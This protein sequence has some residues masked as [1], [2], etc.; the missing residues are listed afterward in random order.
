MIEFAWIK[1]FAALP[2]PLLVYL[3]LPR[4]RSSSGQAL[5]I[6]FFEELEELRQKTASGKGLGWLRLLAV[7]AWILLVCAAARPQWIGDP[8]SMPISG[9]DLLLAVDISGSMKAE[10][11]KISNQ[12]VDRLTMI[13]K[14]AGEFIERRQGDRIGLI[15]FGSRAYLQAPL[16]LDRKTVNQLLQEALIGI[17]GEKTAIGDA[18]G[19]AVKR[20]QQRPGEKKVLIL[21]TDGA[22]T[23]GTIEPLKAAELAKEAKLSIYTIGIG[24]ER[25]IVNSFFG[26]RVVNPSADLDEKTLQKIAELTGGRYFRARESQ[27]LEKIYDLL[28][29]L[30]PVISEDQNLR[31]IREIFFWPMSGALILVFLILVMRRYES[32]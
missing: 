18:L 29:K 17:A 2:L 11:M 7:S 21:L 14:V 9:R 1:L 15:L 8:I 31:P 24:A 12:Q 30:E 25:M 5:K 6:P 22:N 26:N 16:S 10:D 4:A 23:S 19:L 28:D 13:K 27:D 20:L 3:L 32:S